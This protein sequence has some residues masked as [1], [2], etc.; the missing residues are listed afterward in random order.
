MSSNVFLVLV[1]ITLSL[2]LVMICNEAKKSVKQK[3]LTSSL[4]TQL[5][6]LLTLISVCVISTVNIL[7]L[8]G[9]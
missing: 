9:I 3:R 4:V 8:G 1:V 6:I 7:K 5:I 2:H